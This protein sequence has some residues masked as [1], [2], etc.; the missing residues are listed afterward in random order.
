MKR[1]RRLLTVLADAPATWR[2]GEV[3]FGNF[4]LMMS[5]YGLPSDADAM[6]RYIDA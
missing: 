1:Q 4:S 2:Y 3:P 5:G 6:R